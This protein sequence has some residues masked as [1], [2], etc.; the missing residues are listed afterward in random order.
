MAWLDCHDLDSTLASLADAIGTTASTLEQALRDYDD[1][2][3]AGAA[4]DPWQ[5]MPREILQSL[6]TDVSLVVERLD[7]AYYFHGTRAIDPE[8]FRR[9]GIL[10]L[11]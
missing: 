2:R 6:G 1:G 7:G 8:T 11:D 5:L 4:E 3:F 9:R 10:Q